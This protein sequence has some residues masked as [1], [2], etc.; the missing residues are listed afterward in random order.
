MEVAD[1]EQRLKVAEAVDTV[2]RYGKEEAADSFGGVWIDQRAGGIVRVAFT[3]DG[4]RHIQ[5]LRRRFAF[6]EKLALVNARFTAAD[7][8][9]AHDRIVRDMP[10]LRARGIDVLEISTSVPGNVLAVGVSARSRQ[11]AESHFRGAFGE[12]ARV[13]AVDPPQRVN[14][15][16]DYPPMKAGTNITGGGWRCSSA[17]GAW[18]T[19]PADPLNLLSEEVPAYYLITAGHCFDPGWDIS[20][21]VFPLGDAI[22]RVY[23]PNGTS[24]SDAELVTLRNTDVS[25][26]VYEFQDEDN[27]IFYEDISFM[28]LASGDVVGEPVCMSAVT[29]GL[30]CGS[31]TDTYFSAYY[32]SDN[33]TLTHQRLASF[34]SQ[35]GDS[36]GAVYYNRIA[37]G[38]VSGVRS[39][40]GV[41]ENLIYTHVDLA[42]QD[43]RVTLFN[44][45]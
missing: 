16:N 15:R 34:P 21:S 32:S 22:R 18:D 2:Q 31:I 26:L 38:I 42:R 45:D 43:L 9:A 1:F 19:Y 35:G 12:M 11:A 24:R 40:N 7:L 13:A 44:D 20:H 3:H 25:D 39:V 30:Y 41:P 8:T 28:Q 33:A 36:G 5:E 6:P 4:E 27:R 29:S 14:R 10:D 23:Q 17:F 37:K